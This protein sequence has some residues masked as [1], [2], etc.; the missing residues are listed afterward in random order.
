MQLLF[1]ISLVT[2]K[3]RNISLI[4]RVQRIANLE[5]YQRMFNITWDFPHTTYQVWSSL[6]TLKG[7][8]F[9]QM[10]R[11]KWQL[12]QQKD[13]LY[14]TVSKKN[15][16]SFSQQG[17]LFI[18]FSLIFFLLIKRKRQ[19]LCSCCLLFPCYKKKTKY[20]PNRTCLKDCQL[21]EISTNV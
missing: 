11:C 7:Y 15:G 3:K 2:R 21:R 19:S 1:A 9:Y 10:S 12:N 18:I 17:I 16:L 20:F 13:T 14:W 4:E 8:A 6:V 5:K